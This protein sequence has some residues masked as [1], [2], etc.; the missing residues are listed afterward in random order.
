LSGANIEDLERGAA[1][2]KSI[3]D[4]VVE[5][6]NHEDEKVGRIL[7]SMSFLTVGTTIAFSSFLANRTT[8]VAS[9]VDLMTVFF[10]AYVFFLVVGTTI[11]LEAMSPRLHL[12]F[13]KPE[14]E[15][16]GAS[17]ASLESTHFFKSIARR[18]EAS[19]LA[20]FKDASSAELLT[21]ERDDALRQARF[22]AK[23]V[24]LK[25]EFIRLAKWVILVASILLI[26]MVATGVVSYLLM[27]A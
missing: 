23:K 18:D 16:A 9:G 15:E 20:S 2:A 17:S 10:L 3:L 24:T 12:H 27:E 4:D 26:A 1:L 11:M 7:T 8:L 22:L 19:W 25:V 5:S 14:S 21:R 6:S 13:G